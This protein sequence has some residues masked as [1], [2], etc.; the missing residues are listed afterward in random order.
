M[1]F[2]GEHNIKSLNKIFSLIMADSGGDGKSYHMRGKNADHL[3][4]NVPVGTT[5]RDSGGKLLIDIQKHDQKYIAAHGK[6]GL[7]Y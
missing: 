7:N 6:I 3:I 5:I 1:I 4:V 2:K